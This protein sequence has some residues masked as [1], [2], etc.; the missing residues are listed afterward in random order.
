MGIAVPFVSAM[1]GPCSE[2]NAVFVHSFAAGGRK[3]GGGAESVVRKMRVSAPFDSKCG[4][5]ASES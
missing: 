2:I 1:I 4:H 5:G 3:V